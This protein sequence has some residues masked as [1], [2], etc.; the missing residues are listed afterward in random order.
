MD[1]ENEATPE[2]G[3]NEAPVTKFIGQIASRATGRE[4]IPSPPTPPQRTD[5]TWAHWSGTP[6]DAT[7]WY[8]PAVGTVVRVREP[9]QVT[10]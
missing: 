1:L 6:G 9:Q 2:T 3:S 5:R 8:G 4:L 10:R 7:V